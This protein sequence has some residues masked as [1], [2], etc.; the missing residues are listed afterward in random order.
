M[1]M[2]RKVKIS[3]NFNQILYLWLQLIF[4]I[5]DLSRIRNI[6]CWNSVGVGVGTKTNCMALTYIYKLKKKSSVSNKKDS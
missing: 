5:S 4:A 3:I 2:V 6:I 1:L